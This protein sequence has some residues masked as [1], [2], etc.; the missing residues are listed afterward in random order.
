MENLWR[1]EESCT[2]GWEVIESKLTR[3]GCKQKLES[4]LAQ[5]YNPNHLRAIPD[6][7]S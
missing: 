6:N 5:G 3:E 2:T 7:D 4:L 1:I